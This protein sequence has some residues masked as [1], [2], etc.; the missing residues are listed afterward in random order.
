MKKI[1]LIALAVI[2]LIVLGL[3]IFPGSYLS[4][5]RAY[6]EI[7]IQGEGYQLHG[8]VSEGSDTSGKWVFLVH[9]NRQPGQDHE[10][11]R[12][13]GEILPETYSVLAVDLRGF[14]GSVG[15]GEN[16]LPATI[17][18]GEDLKTVSD[19]I[20]N[21]YGVDQDQIVLIG[22]SFGAAQVFSAAQDQDY[23]L[24]IPIGLGDWDALLSSESAVDGY[25]R[26][27]EANTGIQV[28]RNVLIEDAESFTK[29]AL[30]TDCP[31]T[32]VW[33]LYASQDDAIP[34]HSKAFASLSEAC[35]DMVNWSEVPISDH[36]Y[37]TEMYK[38]PEPIRG[39]YSRISLS[40]LKYRLAQILGSLDQQS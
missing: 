27:F 1:I 37:G 6:E 4:N 2:I 30:F 36:M 26:K 15:D 31:E 8:Y 38:L 24:A 28:D 3:L 35:K 20:S 14:G 19:Y 10:L 39:I 18:R 22:H 16:Q 17:D 5:E 34:V 29:G 25:I 11:Y 9:G 32:P 40:F 12:K 13:M 21:N 23:L 7:T 33:M